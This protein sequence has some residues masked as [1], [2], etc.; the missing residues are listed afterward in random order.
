MAKWWQWLANPIGTAI[1]SVATLVN[2]SSDP[3]KVTAD[4]LGLEPDEFN[5]IQSNSPS[6][7]DKFTNWLTDR[8][9]DYTGKSQIEL[10]NKLDREMA[11]EEYQRNLQSIGD[12]AAAY[13][14]AGFNRNILYGGHNGS[15]VSYS[16]PNLQ[17]YSGSAKADTILNRVGK[18]L[19]FIPA[20]YQA[21]AALESIDQAREKTEQ[22]RIKTTAM[23]LSLLDH[24]LGTF[25]KAYSRPLFQVIR[26][27]NGVKSWDST[28]F[29]RNFP[30]TDIHDNKT[31]RYNR[32]AGALAN[33]GAE[34]LESIALK[35]R[36]SSTR[37]SYLGY[38]YDLDRRF[39]AAG[40][41]MG[42]A[43]QGIGSAANLLKSVGSLKKPTINRNFNNNYY[44]PYGY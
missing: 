43:N 20:I 22:S 1:G 2:G 23:G 8:W 9:D 14:A 25:E 32:Y 34:L 19:Q 36:L 6:V 39:G 4:S 41:I 11:E 42:I 27:P 15:P 40:R 44:Y 21:T 28:D 16:A 24:G 26:H 18:V 38:Q 3:S 5:N 13:E 30:E 31:D 35:N 29:L 37:S 33:Y 10:Q 17:A 7:W 12:T